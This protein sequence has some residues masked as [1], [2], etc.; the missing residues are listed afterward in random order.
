MPGNTPTS[1]PTVTPMKQKSSA[2]QESAV[3]NP[4]ARLVRTST[5]SPGERV[6]RQAEA[7]NEYGVAH[8]GKT[9]GERKV[10][11]KSEPTLPQSRH[12]DQQ[13][14][15][16]IKAQALQRDRPEQDCGHD[17]EQRTKTQFR[18]GIAKQQALPHH[19]DAKQH[20]QPG[21]AGREEA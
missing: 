11:P 13:K 17:H 12:K 2:S 9:K 20:E 18:P 4:R 10:R 5:R 21:D 1:V 6:E 14:G 16:R 8:D 15:R 3:S 19:G 7:V